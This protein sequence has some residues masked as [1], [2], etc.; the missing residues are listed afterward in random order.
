MAILWRQFQGERAWLWLLPPL[1]LAWVNL[2][3]GFIAGLA[4]MGAYVV[5]ELLE[6][7]FASRRSAA[8]SRVRRAAP[9]LVATGPCDPAESLGTAHLCG[10][11]PPTAQHGRISVVSSIG[12]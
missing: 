1:M 9:W 3:L 7:P 6:M 8:L 2:H 4:M 5:L 12:G 11:C 10:D